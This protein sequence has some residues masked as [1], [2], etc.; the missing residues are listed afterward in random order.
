V[1]IPAAVFSGTVSVLTFMVRH[2]AGIGSGA[3]A[4]GCYGLRNPLFL[5]VFPERQL[6]YF[7]KEA[8]YRLG[9]AVSIN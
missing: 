9:F 7:Y 4:F 1:V 8:L 2:S 3:V 5:P 6:L